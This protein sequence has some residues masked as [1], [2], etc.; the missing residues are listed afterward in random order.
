MLISFN[1]SS[2]SE[3]KE[4]NSGFLLFSE[5]TLIIKNNGETKSYKLT[6]KELN[7]EIKLSKSL[8]DYKGVETVGSWSTEF[9]NKL[10]ISFNGETKEVIVFGNLSDQYHKD[11]EDKIKFNESAFSSRFTKKEIK[12]RSDDMRERYTLPEGLLDLF[13]HYKNYKK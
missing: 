12:K 3:I 11:L 6:E 8:L 4:G 9:H 5:G 7:K 1:I 2:D 13:L 10:E